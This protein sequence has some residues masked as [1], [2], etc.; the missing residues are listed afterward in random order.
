MKIMRWLTTIGLIVTV[1]ASLG[2]VKFSQI[3]AMIAFGESFPEPSAAVNTVTTEKSLYQ[4]KSKVTGQVVAPKIIEL[5]NEYQGKIVSVGFVPGQAVNKGQVLL[6]LDISEEKARL[7]A[8]DAR[9]TLAQKTVERVGDLRANNR[10]SAE[11]LD[12]AEAELSI[13]R[14]EVENLEVVISKKTITAPFAGTV[15]LNNFHAGQFLAAYTAITTLVG[16]QQRMWID[17]KL[18]QTA[19][20]L[21]VDDVVDFAT[22]ENHS[23]AGSAR[24]IAK[25]PVLTA[26]SR[27]VQYRAEFSNDA[28]LGHN[29]LVNLFVPKDQALS[30]VMVPNSAV[31]RDHFGDYVYLLEKD[32]Q[33]LYRASPKQVQLGN[34][35]KDN[36]VVLSGLEGGEYIATEGSFKLRP[37]LLV[38]P[39]APSSSGTSAAAAGG[40]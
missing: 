9:L 33:G 21:N 8:A 36:Q 10:I 2:F 30:V 22:I 28:T 15:G 25:T 4:A 27:H 26:S 3:Q 16:D 14:S 23:R 13:A 12:Q 35:D 19:M 5:T 11:A 18:P 38:Y 40:K 34:R 32:E 29:T 1:V 6:Q 17:F 7:S 20:P 37:G 39:Q 24:I 31:K